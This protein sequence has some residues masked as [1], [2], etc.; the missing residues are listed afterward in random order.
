MSRAWAAYLV[1]TPLLF[2]TWMVYGHDHSARVLQF[3]TALGLLAGPVVAYAAFRER[4]FAA[5]PISRRDY[6]RARW[7]VATLGSALCMSLSGAMAMAWP[8]AEGPAVESVAHAIV[9][10]AVLSG[11]CF[12][13]AAL[14]SRST[15]LRRIWQ[16]ILDSRLL[17]RPLPIIAAGAV[18]VYVALRFPLSPWPDDRHFP[19]VTFAAALALTVIGYLHRPR[20]ARPTGAHA[21]PEPQIRRG[22]RT[23]RQPRFTGIVLL[24]AQQASLSCILA[25]AMVAAL[26]LVPAGFDGYEGIAWFTSAFAGGIRFRYAGGVF[27]W[28]DSGLW[29]GALIFSVQFGLT[30]TMR[31]LR[32]LPIPTHRLALVWVTLACPF[33]L[34]FAAVASLV[35]VLLLGHAP[36]IEIASF[37]LANGITALADSLHIAGGGQFLLTPLVVAA[38]VAYVLGSASSTPAFLAPFA[39]QAGLGVLLVIAA[40]LTNRVALRHAAPYRGRPFTPVLLSSR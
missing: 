6:W 25:A 10:I 24:F 36:E 26:V 37:V 35:Q 40:Y 39:G 3:R 16:R 14:V 33:W 22:S 19:G 13:V 18:P 7:M 15:G 38:P 34:C 11:A 5:L 12:G 8:L 27:P 23:A 29:F 2:G 28:I 9:S 20:A 30:T 21:A 31:Q 4:L 1:W 17:P 32:A